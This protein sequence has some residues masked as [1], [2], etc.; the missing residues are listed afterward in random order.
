MLPR[1][2]I[3]ADPVERQ[4]AHTTRVYISGKALNTF[5]SDMSTPGL[6]GPPDWKLP[7]VG[8]DLRH[9][10]ASKPHPGPGPHIKRMSP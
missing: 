7:E 3:T 6:S 10:C 2:L 5:S 9:L 8:L 4:T 1:G